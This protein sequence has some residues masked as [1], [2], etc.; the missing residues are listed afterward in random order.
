MKG[1]S[2]MPSED[3]FTLLSDGVNWGGGHEVVALRAWGNNGI[4]VQAALLAV[5]PGLPGALLEDAPRAI[6]QVALSDAGATVTN[7]KTRPMSPSTAESVS[8][9]T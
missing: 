5:H 4:R 6:P 3:N 7:G 8:L 9:T 2:Q 1:R